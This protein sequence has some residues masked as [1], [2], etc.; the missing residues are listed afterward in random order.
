MS[1]RKLIYV[2]ELKEKLSNVQFSGM[3]YYKASKAVDECSAVDAVE[4]VRCKDCKHREDERVCPMCFVES[5]DYDDDG[6]IETDYI[7]HDYTI[8]YGFC[9]MGE[10]WEDEEGDENDYI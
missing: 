4:I 1:D 5:I 2:D 7:Y 8:D 6:Y 9:Y 3:G 10:K